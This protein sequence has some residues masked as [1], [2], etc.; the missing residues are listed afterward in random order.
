MGSQ[1]L[2]KIVKNK[3]APPFKTAQFELEFGKGISRE[4]E[5][6]EFGVKQKFISK[7][8]AFYNLNGQNFHG[9]DA[10]KKFLAENGSVREELIAKLREKLLY[11]KIEKEP[12]IEVTDGDPSEEI[13]SP[14]ST[15][16]DAVA[17]VEA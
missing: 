7:S 2:A 8:G 3:L 9:R 11:A 6:I 17:A 14:D 4:A 12:A 5:I 13:V 16:E 1:V 10:F 15:D